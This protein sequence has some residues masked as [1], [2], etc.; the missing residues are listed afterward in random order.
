MTAT[1]PEKPEK[2]S[3][4]GR[5][6]THAA[7]LIA[8]LPVVVAAIRVMLYSG[9]DPVVMKTL[10]ETL[11][12]LTLLLGT[13]LPLLPLLVYF[14]FQMLMARTPA[15]NAAIRTAKGRLALFAGAAFWLLL[16]P[17]PATVWLVGAVVFGLVTGWLLLRYVKPW[18]R[19]HEWMAPGP[20][21]T[22]PTS[23]AYITTIVLLVTLLVVPQGMWLPLERVTRSGSADQFVYVLK[24]AEGW[25]TTITNNRSIDVFKSSE[26]TARVVCDQGQYASILTMMTG[27]DPD[28]RDKC[29]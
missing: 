5:A 23:P 11:N 25:T 27:A 2:P 3:L 17:F 20:G 12:I 21:K 13:F 19:L 22:P 29:E 8:I 4:L 26:V 16:G 14:A 28:T 15:F 10:V 7:I 9:G 1:N 18:R 6:W 24:D